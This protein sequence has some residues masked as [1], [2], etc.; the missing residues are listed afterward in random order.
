MPIEIKELHIKIKVDEG[1]NKGNASNKGAAKEDKSQLIAVC[2][3]EVMEILRQ[4][5]E[6]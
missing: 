6:R 4:Q 1:A 3:E 2:V 5:K